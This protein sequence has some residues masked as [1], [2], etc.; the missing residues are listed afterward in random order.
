MAAKASYQNAQIDVELLTGIRVSAKTQARIVARNPIADAVVGDEVDELALDGGMVRLTTPKGEASEWKQYKALRVNNNNVGMA[1]FQADSSLLNWVETLC[2]AA[3]LYCLGDGHAG[4]WSLYQQMGRATQRDEILD[5]FHLNENLH[6]VGGSLKRIKQAE[7]LLWEGKV[8]EASQ[9][10]E[11][12]RS[13]QAK[14]FRAYLAGHRSRIPNYR[15]YQMEGLPIGSGPVE[16]LIKQIDAR[17]QVTGAQ[18]KPENVSQLLSLRC[19]YL[20]QQL[21]LHSLARG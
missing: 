11:G 10:F 15:Y 3:V 1:W 16:S 4:V 21:T 19:S 13:K 6:K 5:W 20:N 14:R 2:L 7:S 9:L 17:I 12:L 18:W 8:E